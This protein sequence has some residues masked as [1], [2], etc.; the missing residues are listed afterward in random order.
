VV[1]E[2]YVLGEVKFG[3]IISF[4]SLQGD[5][6]SIKLPEGSYFFDY[7]AF[8][9]SLIPQAAR[10]SGQGKIPDTRNTLFWMDHCE[11]PKDKSLRINFQ[12]ATV[13]G[14]YLILIRGVSSRGDIVYG[15]NQFKVD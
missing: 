15:L 12:A 11:L 8:Q 3:G 1:P 13:P 10:F 6:G 14:T 2:V 5:L 9:P 7:T 4:T